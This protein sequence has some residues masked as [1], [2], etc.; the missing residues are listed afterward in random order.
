MQQAAPN[1]NENPHKLFPVQRLLENFLISDT[2]E[3]PK[4]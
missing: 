4:F 3:K 1:L 2:D